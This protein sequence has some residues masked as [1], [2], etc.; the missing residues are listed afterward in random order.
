MQNQIMAINN[1]STYISLLFILP[2][3]RSWSLFAALPWQLD[4]LDHYFWKWQT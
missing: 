2:V 4:L 3:F 1:K